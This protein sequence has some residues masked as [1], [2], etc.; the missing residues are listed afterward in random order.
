MVKCKDCNG[1]GDICDDCNGECFM[2][3]H[4]MCEFAKEKTE[5]GYAICPACNGTGKVKR[6]TEDESIL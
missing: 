1:T 3:V 4:T 6:S 5:F 2:G